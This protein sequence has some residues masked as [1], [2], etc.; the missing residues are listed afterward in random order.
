MAAFIGLSK[1]VEPG[2]AAIPFLCEHCQSSIR[3]VAPVGIDDLVSFARWFE[4]EHAECI[5]DAKEDQ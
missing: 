2:A 1:P 3:L 5:L 4:N